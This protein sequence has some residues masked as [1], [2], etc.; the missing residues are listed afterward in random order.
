[1]TLPLTF[2]LLCDKDNLFI[3]K[4]MAGWPYFH[5]PKERQT[6]REIPQL[7]DCFEVLCRVFYHLSALQ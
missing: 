7:A 4:G 1:M 5:K 3:A 2:T 6:D